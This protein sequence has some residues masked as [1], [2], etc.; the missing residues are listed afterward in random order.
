MCVYNIN[1][2]D[3]NVCDISYQIKEEASNIIQM[4][5]NNLI[6]FYYHYNSCQLKVIKINKHSLEEI[7]TIKLLKIFNSYKYYE[8][9]IKI[10]KEKICI[11][12]DEYF[13]ILL[14][15]NGKLIDNKIEFQLPIKNNFSINNCCPINE[16]EIA[17]VYKNKGKI[18]GIGL[19]S[20]LMFYD[21]KKFMEI[22]TLKLGDGYGSED[23]CFLNENLIV[24]SVWKGLIIIDIKKRNVVKE[25]KNDLSYIKLFQLNNNLICAF[26]AIDFYIYQFENIND[27]SICK[28]N[29]LINSDIKFCKFCFNQKFIIIKYEKKVIIYKNYNDL[30]NFKN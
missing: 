24:A 4:E 26:D 7:Q 29:E 18:L 3:V 17:I 25:I 2:N 10:C 16:N 22:K 8:K 14:Y 20:F 21:I 9:I 13:K 27:Y 23:V 30:F 5:D 19:N 6:E 1:N 11:S 12:N 15:Q 28:K